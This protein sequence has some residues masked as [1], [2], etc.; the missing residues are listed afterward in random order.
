MRGHQWNKEEDDFLAENY[1]KLT[2]SELKK[3]INHSEQAIQTRASMKGF[4]NRREI[5]DYASKR[6]SLEDKQ[7]ILDNYQSTS[8]A[9]IA[10]VLGRS[11]QAVITRAGKLGL[12][13]N[14][15]K[16]IKDNIYIP[17][18]ISDGQFYRNWAYIR[19]YF[20]QGMKYKSKG[21]YKNAN[22]INIS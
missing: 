7:Y 13:K 17:D 11:V 2:I 9:K 8:A 5:K 15:H 14:K 10:E 18:I 20:T 6:W 1:K 4:T 12:S 3:K 19:T 21:R 16:D 22:K